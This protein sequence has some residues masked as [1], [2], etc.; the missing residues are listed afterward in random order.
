MDVVVYGAGGHARVVIDTMRQSGEW[1]P[2]ACL[3]QDAM[4]P[5]CGLP[6]LAETSAAAIAA[7]G[8]THAFIAVGDATVRG[9]LAVQ[10]REAGFLLATVVSPH[11]YVSPDAS[12]GAGTL[13]AAGAVVQPGTTIAELGIVNTRASVDHDCNLGRLAHIAPGATLCGGVRLGDEVWIGAGSVVVEYRTL[14]DRVY[15]AAGAVVT[16]DFHAAN[17]RLAGVPAAAMR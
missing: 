11:A 6:V 15:V 12:L 1:S 9:R 3:A 14:A 5:F 2:I 10:A 16:R 17:A 4:D 7:R 8:V 13:V